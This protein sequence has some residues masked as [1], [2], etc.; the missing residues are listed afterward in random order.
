MMAGLPDIVAC[1]PACMCGRVDCQQHKRLPRMGMFVGFET[2]TPTGGDP[3]PIQRRV[4]YMIRACEG[5]VFVV[6]SVQ[7][8]IDALD[9][10]WVADP[11]DAMG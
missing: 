4:H 10:L 3:S 7:D 11:P 1:V 5:R 9:R 8:A 6:R 2:K